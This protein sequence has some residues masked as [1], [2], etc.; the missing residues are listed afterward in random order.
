MDT[1]KSGGRLNAGEQLT[2][3]DGDLELKMQ[4]DGN[5]VLYWTPG[6]NKVLWASNTAG[7]PGAYVC[8]Q[9]DGNLVVYN[10]GGKP[11]WA[12]NTVNN[13][14][15]YAFVQDDGNFIVDDAS[16]K[17]LWATGTWGLPTPAHVKLVQENLAKMQRY[18]DFVAEQGRAKVLNAYLL[19]S[20]TD[21]SDPGTAFGL[22]M[23]EAAF[24]AAGA[25]FG[26]IG[27]F[28]STF[29]SGMLASWAT[30]TPP[31]LNKT[32]ADMILRMQETSLAVDTQLAEY[33]SNTTQYWWTEFTYNGTSCALYRLTIGEF[34]AETDPQFENMV[35]AALKGLDL[36][37]W[38]TVLRANYVV[39]TWPPG[40]LA[41]TVNGDPNYPPWDDV[42]AMIKDN[43][44][45]TY[46]PV[47]GRWDEG[48]GHWTIGWAF[49]GVNIGTGPGFAS[50][51]SMSRDACN[52]LFIDSLPGT[53][54]NPDG[55][56]TR[57]TV[58]HGLG[59]R[60]ATA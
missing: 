8:M 25:P 41:Y 32:F 52:Y 22:N 10:T 31:S 54:I 33:Y 55:L 24:S 58:L 6:K 15:A 19:L 2:S 59:I 11:L 42:K 30:D 37:I 14:G 51:G 39:T 17:A 18:N 50:D 21:N 35:A 57:E 43:P 44:A 4:S 45:Y 20:E 36:Q 27:S 23:M 28:A 26:P 7:K 49:T 53:V 9:V 40:D 47:W 48:M 38:R 12:S 1:L 13:P 3:P 60:T 16:G 34:P 5:F 56:Y 29:L 46:I